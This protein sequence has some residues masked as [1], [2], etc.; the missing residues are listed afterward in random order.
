MTTST[1]A[2][3]LDPEFAVSYALGA[4]CYIQRRVF[5]WSTD[6][7]QE[8][9]EA[10]RLARRAIQLDKEDPIVLAMVGDTLA[11]VLGEVEEGATL[12]WQAIN[13]NPNYRHCTKLG[14]LGVPLAWRRQRRDRAIPRCTALKST[15]SVDQHC[16]EWTG[17]RS[18]LRWPK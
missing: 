13:L 17:L 4:T 15:R 11:Y 7:A 1:I 8:R 2:N 18:F 10:R 9:T 16:P 6:A 14:R 5:G 3:G 12:I